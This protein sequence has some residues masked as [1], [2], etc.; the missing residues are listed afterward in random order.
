MTP[1]EFSGDLC[2]ERFSGLKRKDAEQDKRL[3]NHG[4]RLDSLERHEVLVDNKIEHLIEKIEDLIKS[5]N[6]TFKTLLGTGVGLLIW[7]I[8][9]V[10]TQ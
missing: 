4:E 1:K 10:V 6:W 8:K 7:A 5:L 9:E 2:D 3:D